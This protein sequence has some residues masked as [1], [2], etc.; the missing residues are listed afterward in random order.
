[1]EISTSVNAIRNRLDELS[2][3]SV[4]V[5]LDENEELLLSGGTGLFTPFYVLTFGGPTRAARGR[6]IVSAAHDVHIMWCTVLNVAP[7]PDSRN[8]LVD[9]ALKLTG[10]RPPGCGEMITEGGMDYS[11][12]STTVRPTRYIKRLTWTYRTN[13]ELNI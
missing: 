6:G 3:P 1:M 12:G 5:Y 8:A 2:P 10:Y 11:V 9:D 7:T 13:L 4:E